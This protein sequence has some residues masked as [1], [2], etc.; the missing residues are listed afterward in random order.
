MRA[1]PIALALAVLLA[2]PAL[3]QSRPPGWIADS[4][5]GCRVWNEAPQANEAISWSG[6]CVG[7]VAEGRGVLHWFAGGQPNGGYEGG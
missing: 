1:A 4:K 6:P 7:G 5:T 2:T 3:A